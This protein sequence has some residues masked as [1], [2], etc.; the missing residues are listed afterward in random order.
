M[1][2]PLPRRCAVSSSR[3]W[4][5]LGLAML[6]SAASAVAATY[7]VDATGGVPRIVVDGKPVRA[8]IFWGAPGSMPIAV[9]PGVAAKSFEFTPTDDE[10]SRTT[11]HFRFGPEPGRIVLD[12]VR[13][14]D[15]TARREVFRADFEGGPSDFQRG[16]SMWPVGVQNTVGKVDVCDGAGR[17]GSRG[18]VV[19]QAKVAHGYRPDFHIYTRAP[20]ALVK[21][22]RYRVTFWIQVDRLRS[23]RVAL[24]RPGS[25]FTLLGGPPDCYASQI[26][27]AGAVGVNLVSFPV[28]LPW[29]KP[30]Q[31]VDFR[32]SERQCEAVLRA[33]PKAL[34]VP[35]IGVD[36]P[37]WWCAAHS[38]AK[39]TWDGGPQKR[40]YATVASVE[41]RREAAS[42]LAALVEHL[43]A[44]FGDRMA[45]YHPCGQNTGE[46]FYADTW[47]RP[48]NG[49][50]AADRQAWRAWL[51]RRYPTDAALQAVWHQTQAT[52]A[53]A[54][55]PTPAV[56]RASP[57]GTFRDP[58]TERMLVDWAEFQQETMAQCVCELARA[59]RQASRGNKLVVFF[60][61][62]VF[63]FGPVNN[64]PATSGH[65]AL[66]RVLQCP[67]IDIVCSPI[68][69]FDRA[70][71]ESAP[72]M[73]AAES[74]ALAGKMWLYEDDTSTYLSTGTPP[75]YK[76]RV[77]TLAQTNQLLLRNTSQCALRN[78]G[79]WW[80]DLTASG[81]FNDPGMWA[82]MARLAKLDDPLLARPRPFRPQIAA[83]IDERAMLWVTPQGTAVT[84]PG[85]YE[86]RRA[87]GR[88]GAPYGQYLQDDV[89]QGRVQAQLYVMLTAWRLSTE[90][91]RAL[92]ASLRGHTRLWCYAPGAI[93]AERTSLN[94]MRE[95]TGFRLKPVAANIKARAVPTEAGRRLGLAQ[96]LGTDRP[97]APL[98]AAADARADEVLAVYADGSAAVALRKSPEGTSIF[99]GPPG[100]SSELLR[101]A[102]RQAG[103]HLFTQTDCNV[104]ANGPYLSLHT[105]ADGPLTLDTGRKQPVVDLLTG[106]TLGNGPRITLP[107]QKG[108]TRVLKIEQ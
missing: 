104:Y 66:R 44:K 79:T 62:Y 13:V 33:N 22:H 58:Q 18:L 20:L 26:R 75:G 74:V 72:A 71:T 2:H 3:V 78:F 1:L 101:L 95:L 84:R 61:G 97:V 23:L 106:Q 51:A 4:C 12:D 83:V 11:I 90:Q 34:L 53:G 67:D 86:V 37:A 36:A 89:E 25:S 98:F 45:G 94:A 28:S 54:E 31:A 43:E 39:M 9:A 16:W 40:D 19:T 48:L 87:L 82:E 8:R 108:Q 47:A 15:L 80:M 29:P 93:D 56:R 68:S 42:R 7:R 59:V 6:L 24:Y 52:R 77:A 69:Y 5:A 100:L 92:G 50:A 102:A 64:G 27:L 30:G 21:E 105:A 41:Y 17:A 46:F 57:A 35:R 10:P 38:E 85:V 99:V 107:I 88:T 76:E 65:Y 91:R 55:V 103:V 70:L 49:Y 81:W 32:A 73:T 60:Y 63:E 96:P 14:E